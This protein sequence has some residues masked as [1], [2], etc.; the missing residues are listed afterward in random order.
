MKR[1]DREGIGMQEKPSSRKFLTKGQG[2][3]TLSPYSWNSLSFE[4]CKAEVEK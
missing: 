4:K 3:N 1:D 2:I